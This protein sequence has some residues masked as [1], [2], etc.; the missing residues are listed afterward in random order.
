[1]LNLRVDFVERFFDG[2]DEIFDGLLLCVEVPASFG[3]KSLEAG[4]GQLKE[5]LVVAAQ[6]IG[7]KCLK[8]LAKL[9]AGMR[10]SATRILCT[11]VMR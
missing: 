2:G 5:G 10:S 6:G 4:L 9:V 1:M 8:G 3:L 11:R 7:G